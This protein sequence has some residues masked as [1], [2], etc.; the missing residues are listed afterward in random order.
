MTW[1]ELRALDVLALPW[2][3]VL[4]WPRRW[5]CM[6][7]AMGMAVVAWVFHT[8]HLAPERQAYA[9]ARQRAA[10]VQQQ[11]AHD[12]AAA[13][14]R[15][16]LQQQV[17]ALEAQL[18][19]RRMSPGIP[20]GASVLQQL[21]LLEEQSSDDGGWRVAVKQLSGGSNGR[22]QLQADWPGVVHALR[23][24]NATLV[25]Q[26]LRVQ[27][28]QA[29][30]TRLGRQEG[31]DASH[32]QAGQGFEDPQYSVASLL[33]SMAWQAQPGLSA[34]GQQMVGQLLESAEVP[35]ALPG[36][37]QRSPFTPLTALS[38][39]SPS[40]P[41][42]SESDQ[43]L[44]AVWPDA[45]HEALSLMRTNGAWANEER[46]AQAL[47]LPLSRMRLLGVVQGARHRMALV[48]AGGQTWRV[49]IGERLGSEGHRVRDIRAHAVML[50]SGAG[51]V[52]QDGVALG[53]VR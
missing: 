53:G 18:Q 4:Y 41:L 16:Q 32:Q 25:W 49:G 26:E 23:Q 24:L 29:H 37:M 33:V 2:R 14:Q 20:V 11:Q 31:G 1:A 48:L 8:V 5:Q 45:G 43:A 6:L 17:R 28:A 52:Q 51:L 35:R 21:Q 46:R 10:V 27:V 30:Q 34:P 13:G 50:E 12:R 3:R 36:V 22:L 47:A 42:H 19:E 7:L 44:S 15:A 9:Q 39:T 40:P 38:V